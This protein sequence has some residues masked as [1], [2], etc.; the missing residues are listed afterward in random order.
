MS[1]APGAGVEA[2]VEGF[3]LEGLEDEVERRE[4]FEKVA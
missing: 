1:F 2:G 4:G 3:D